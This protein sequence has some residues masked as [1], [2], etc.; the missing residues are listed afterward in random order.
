[1]KA[2]TLMQKQG[3]S[4]RKSIRYTGISNNMLYAP[5]KPRIIQIDKEISKMVHQVAQSRPTYGTRR[6]AATMSRITGRPVNCKKVKKIYHYLGRSVSAKP[7]KEII[8]S[9][10]RLKPVGP[11][12]LWK[13]DMTYIWCGQDR[14]C[15]LFNILCIYP[16]MG[17]ICV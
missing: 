3:L 4:T 5:K 15:Y 8:R 1:M 6:M 9:R 13:A 12:Q 2:L 16:R 17:R 14:W 10:K 7:K 11:D